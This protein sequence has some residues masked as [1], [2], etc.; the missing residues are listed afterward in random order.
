[1]VL[2]YQ[3]VPEDLDALVSVRN[4]EDLKHMIEEHDRHESGGI[5]MLRA[6]LF[7][8]KPVVVENQVQAAASEPYVLEQR[9]IDAINGIIRT[10]P[11][12]RPSPIRAY[13]TSS[14]CS[15]P[16]SNSNSPDGHTA[17]LVPES[18]PFHASHSGR[19][20]MHRVRSSP[21]ITTLNNL[22]SLTIQ[23]HDHHSHY[24]NQSQSQSQHPHPPP[25][26]HLAAYPASRTPPQDPQVVVGGGIGMGRPPPIMSLGKTD[27]SNR[28]NNGYNYYYSTSRPPK[29]YA[30]Y[31][32]SAAAYG[33]GMV[34]RVNSMPQSPRKSIWE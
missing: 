11:R 7:P 29:G 17:E 25:S 26:L 30:C 32:D 6:F 9:Y 22:H 10:S 34:E 4:D 3:L 33:N 27:I 21:S 18:S 15:S 20:A 23:Q 8:S 14:T 19:L 12:R 16:K 24:H 13:C 2:K 31:D 5:P 28:S 1:M